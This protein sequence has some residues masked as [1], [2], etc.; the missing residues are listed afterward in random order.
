MILGNKKLPLV[1]GI[2][3]LTF[4]GVLLF[5]P[6]K[7]LAATFTVNSTGDASDAVAGDGNCD[8]GGG[9]CTLRAAIQETNALVGADTINFNIAGSGLHTISPATVYPDI[10]DSLTIDGSTQ[11]GASCGTLVPT[12]L[13]ATS[14]TPHNLLVEI[15]LSNLVGGNG[16][17]LNGNAGNT[18]IRGLILNG[19]V[20]GG[21]IVNNG[22]PVTTIECNYFGT[23][24]SGTT[25]V[26]NNYSAIIFNSIN[27]T[28]IQNNLISGSGSAINGS[29]S[30]LTISNNLIGTNAAGTSSLGANAS[31]IS[32][33]FSTALIQHNVVVGSVNDGLF[34]VGDNFDIKGNYIGAG[35]SGNAL[36]NGGS[37]ITVYSSSNFRIGGTTDADRNIISANTGDGIHIYSNCGGGAVYLSMIFGNYVGT[38]TDGT[39]ANG[40]GNHQAGIEVNEYQGSCGS[41]YQ[42]QIGG[43]NAGEANI[44]AGNDQQGVL[45]HQDNNHDVF[46]IAVLHNKIFGNG[47]IGID[48]A[49]DAGGDGVATDDLGPNPLNGLHITYPTANSNNY[50]NR[51]TVNSSVYSSGKLTVNY[52]FIANLVDDSGDGFSMLAKDLVGY[53][54][55]FYINDN[56]TDGAF[57]GYAQQQTYLGSFI[58]DGNATNATHTFDLPSYKNGQTITATAT[59]LWTKTPGDATIPQ[60]C[61]GTS[62]RTGN[63]PPYSYLNSCPN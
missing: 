39:V 27:V 28:T 62:E 54:L 19:I 22:A 5:S 36:G 32:G 44:I 60:G 58:I 49:N 8:D 51:P 55:D 43:D 63:S 48:L 41:V 33:T 12:N 25:A 21:A 40:Y 56:A 14:N 29:G 4:S 16:F 9:N 13:P 2:G 47:Q 26:P 46:S 15:D 50:L 30:N 6:H 11:S 37:G 57:P 10:G 61:N 17:T 38:K 34:I 35:L 3:L 42:H 59:L 53:R 1:I 24:A 52:N 18:T 23:N 45:I 31:G 7:A 20:N